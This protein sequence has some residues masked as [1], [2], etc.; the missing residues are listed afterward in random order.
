MLLQLTDIGE[1]ITIPFPFYVIDHPEGVVLVDTGQSH[2]L[3]EDPLNYGPYGAPGLADF[4]ENIDM[5]EDEEARPLIED[6]GY[7]ASEVDV[8]IQSHLHMDHAGGISD[9]PDAKF[10]VSQEEMKYASAPEPIQDGFYQEGDF[11]ALR[12]A[13]FDVDFTHGNRYDVFGDGSIVTIPTPGHTPGHQSVK[14]ELENEGTVILG[15]DISH[16]RDGYEQ[17]LATSFDWSTT[18]GNQSR[19]KMKNI[20][21]RED[22]PVYVNHDSELTDRD[23]PLT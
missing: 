21:Q 8:V 9:F 10:V 7:S 4:V 19:R 16:Q 22:A 2:E 12:S 20:A 17:N 18:I 13:E 6:L 23:E 1:T 3:V 15:M 5:S 14:V 11:G